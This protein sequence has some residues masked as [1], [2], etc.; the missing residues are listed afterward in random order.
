VTI[1][2]TL[3]INLVDIDM[4]TSFTDLRRS[5]KIIVKCIFDYNCQNHMLDNISEVLFERGEL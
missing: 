1:V 4:I 3:I 2:V 5:Y